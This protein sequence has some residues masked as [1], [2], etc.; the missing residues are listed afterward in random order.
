MEGHQLPP[1]SELAFFTQPDGT[2]IK[3]LEL[4]GAFFEEDEQ[5]VEVFARAVTALNDEDGMILDETAISFLYL[6]QVHNIYKVLRLD[7]YQA[8]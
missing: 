2:T 6:V 4:T 3:T 7:G 1:G 8:P 5:G